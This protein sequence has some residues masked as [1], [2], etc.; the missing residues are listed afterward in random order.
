MSGPSP[1][2]LIT[3]ASSGIGAAAARMLAAEGWRLV[4]AAR[5]I[6]RLDALAAE[7]GGSDHAV[8]VGATSP[9]GRISTRRPSMRCTRWASLPGSNSTGQ[10]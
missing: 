10:E 3:G 8:A 9:T 6:E 5:S 7:L 1:V 2:I 4:L